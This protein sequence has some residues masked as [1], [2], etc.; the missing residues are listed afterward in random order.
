M[1]KNQCVGCH[2]TRAYRWSESPSGERPRPRQSFHGVE[3]ILGGEH[4]Q[5]AGATNRGVVD[6]IRAGE[7]SGMG[8]CSLR[9][10]GNSPRLSPR[11]P[12][13]PRRSPCRGHEL[14]RRSE[15]SWR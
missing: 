12:A 2:D 15:G 3:E 6:I 5:H 4:A 8:R 10:L 9:T 7:R 11:V 1:T 13:Y 14:A